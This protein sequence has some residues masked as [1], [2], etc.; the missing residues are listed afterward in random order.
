MILLQNK[1]VALHVNEDSQPHFYKSSYIQKGLLLY[2]DDKPICGEGV[3][4][5]VPV[6]KYEDKTYFPKK[7][8]LFISE[9]NSIINVKKEFE[10]NGVFRIKIFGKYINKKLLY[11]FTELFSKIHR[12]HR[13][14]RKILDFFLM[15]ARYIM[16][17]P[18]DLVDTESKGIIAVLYQIHENIISI[19]V[20]C[21][22]LDRGN[23][24]EICI[25]NEQG[26]DF[27]RKYRDSDGKILRDD[28]ISSW[29]KVKADK[30]EFSCDEYGIR[31][32]LSNITGYDLFMGREKFK[33]HL[34]WT[35]FAYIISPTANEFE[36]KLD[37]QIND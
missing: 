4:F 32:G 33:Y 30:A 20:D 28:Q 2:Y 14:I 37:L 25:M 35:G 19:K 13:G 9:E 10:I 7:C 27:F 22:R 12:E 17:R 1:K 5:G 34:A 18:A 23:C 3:G 21:S 15:I 11:G 31:F 29:E 24:K 36:Y 16:G 8:K 26:A 6:V